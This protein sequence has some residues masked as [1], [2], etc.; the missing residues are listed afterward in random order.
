MSLMLQQARAP[1]R[2]NRSQGDP[3]L[4]DWGRRALGWGVQTALGLTGFGGAAAA[5]SAATGGGVN[6]AR[7][8]LERHQ[9]GPAVQVMVPRPG[10]IGKIQRAVPGGATGTMVGPAPFGA[11]GMACETG[12]RPNKTSYFL[13]DG[14]FIEKGTR[15]VKRRQRNPMNPRA[16]SR[17][18]GRIDAGKRFQNR[19][20]QISTG[21]FTAAGKKKSCG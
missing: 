6:G 21:R 18:I 11:N 7:R 14:T 3:G 2:A 12:F 20:S 15:C 17:A 5:V 9:V 19:M 4:R 10:L 13:K 8:P 1:Y 16:L